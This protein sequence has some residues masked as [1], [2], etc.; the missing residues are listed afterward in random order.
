MIAWW[1]PVICFIIIPEFRL[2]TEWAERIQATLILPILVALLKFCRIEL[3]HLVIIGETS[4]DDTLWIAHELR[5]EIEILERPITLDLEDYLLWFLSRL[6]GF[7][8]VKRRPIVE[9]RLFWRFWVIFRIVPSWFVSIAALHCMIRITL[10][11]NTCL[12]AFSWSVE[13]TMPMTLFSLYLIL[14]LFLIENHW[15]VNWILEERGS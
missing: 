15:R 14:L 10:F 3:M 6:L 12:V 9:L 5:K 11:S 7:S 4:L 2:N 8:L 13:T 1:K